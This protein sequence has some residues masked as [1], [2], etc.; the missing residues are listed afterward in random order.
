[1]EP[2]SDA[3]PLTRW[4]FEKIDRDM[5]FLRACAREVLTEIG[6][7]DLAQLLDTP[8]WPPDRPLPAR[9]AQVI[10]MLFQLLNLAEEN[11]A[12]QVARSREAEGQVSDRGGLWADTLRRLARAGFSRRTLAEALATTPVEPVFTAHP[13]EAKRWSVL[14]IHRR[15]Y[16]FLVE[17]ENGMYTAAERSRIRDDIKT[18]IETLWRT[19]EI[20]VEK[21][22]VDAERRNILYYLENQ[23]PSVLRLVDARFERAWEACE[24]AE[25]GGDPIRPRP[26]LRFGTWIGGDRDGHPLVT[27]QVTRETLLELRSH[28]VRVLDRQLADLE[29]AL[30]LSSHVQAPPRSH[31]AV[32]AERAGAAVDTVLA[33]EEPW[34]AAVRLLRQRLPDHGGADPAGPR[35]PNPY[36][37]PS[38]LRRDLEDLS[39]SLRQVRAGRLADRLVEPTLR[40]LEVLGFHLAAVDMRQNSAFHDRAIASLLAFAGVPDGARY[41]E[42][43]ETRRRAFLEAELRQPRPFAE[44]TAVIGEEADAVLSTYRVLAEHIRRNGR[45]GVGALIV[46]MTRGLADLLGVYLLGRE[47][48]LVRAGADGLVSLLPVVP[49]FET[50]SD[51][52]HAP[53]IVDAFLGHPIT[54]RSLACH[55]PSWNERM[56]G[57]AGGTDPDA[58]RLSGPSADP[59]TPVLPVMIGYSD[60]NKDAGILASQ[61]ALFSA[62]RALTAVGRLHGVRLQFFHGRG[63]T[64]SR[65]AGPTHRFLD[66]LPAGTLDAGLRVTEQGEVIAQKYNNHLTAALNLELIAAGALRNR[67]LPASA[68]GSRGLEEL[69]P[70]LART[71]AEVYRALLETPGF[72]EFYRAATPIDVIEQSRIG[73]RPSRRTKGHS[74]STLRAIP[75]VFSWTQARFYLPGWYGVG[76]ALQRLREERPS[77]HG[78][79][80]AGWTQWTFLRYLVYNVE[81]S[82]ESASEDWMRAY[83]GLVEDP[84][85]REVFL[86]LILAEYRRTRREVA[87]LAGGPLPERRPRFFR[88]L[89]ARDAG[90]ALLHGEQIRLLRDWRR[91]PGEERFR[92]LLLNVNAVASGLRT[93]G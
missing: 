66:A 6:E 91:N 83:A 69:L 78:R 29:A 92:E 45:A 89:H 71:S 68:E 82:L 25:N 4:G 58:S 14:A 60:S 3:S 52:Q 26:V 10:S 73:S 44:A 2:T 40:T 9:G 28:A 75:W 53:A 37:F 1:M 84:G 55:D 81:S 18:A 59:S 24:V 32:L 67:L 49:L 5:E 51:L 22:R 88:T 30:V 62:Q 34:A 20:L 12:N 19:G 43:D 57:V 93:T 74:L 38:E 77:E 33:D 90:L 17:L 11:T 8:A 36:R 80:R 87:D 54:R 47:S 56:A 13:T 23:M 48:G 27:A 86:G 31:I 35:G 64:V 7:R 85:L 61:W 16:R 50:W 63:G 39:E 76:S 41:A 70:E 46:S 21:P 15:L 72:I 42:W 65:G 79:L